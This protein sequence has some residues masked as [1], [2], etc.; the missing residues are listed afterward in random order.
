MVIVRSYYSS[1]SLL[2]F[3]ILPHYANT[4]I[5]KVLNALRMNDSHFQRCYLIFFF[6]SEKVCC[7]YTLEAPREVCICGKMKKKK[8]LSGLPFTLEL[9]IFQAI[10][11]QLYKFGNRMKARLSWAH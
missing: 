2:S 9:R 8:Y 10:T 5:L 4:S 1:E 11:F 3:E 7:G 6:L